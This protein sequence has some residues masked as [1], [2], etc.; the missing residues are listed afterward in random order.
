MAHWKSK[1]EWKDWQ[2]KKKKMESGGVCSLE[3][4]ALVCKIKAQQTRSICK[5]SVQRLI[6]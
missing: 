5:F 6:P 3:R 4:C 1:T 2:K